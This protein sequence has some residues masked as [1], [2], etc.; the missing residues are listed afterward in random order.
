MTVPHSIDPRLLMHAALD[1]ELDDTSADAFK[2]EIADSPILAVE[3]EKL[4]TLRETVRRN[5]RKEPAPA[6]LALRI[7]AMSPPAPVVEPRG[8]SRRAPSSWLAYAASIVIAAGLASSATFV[9]LAPQRPNVESTIVAAHMRGLLATSPVDVVS[10]DRHTVKPWFDA[11]LAISPPVVDLSAEGFDLVGGRADVIA[12][13]PAPTL[14]YRHRQH[15]ISVTAIPTTRSI[16]ARAA[17]SIAGYKIATWRDA[18]FTY[19]A[20]SDIEQQDLDAFVAAF[21]RA[22]RG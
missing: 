11:R 13:A 8:F 10:T 21:Q 4:V 5:L 15:L 22:S 7:K 17:G 16:D 19:W 3:Y 6:G 9:A 20:T 2:R 14:V 1:G 12:T 18:D